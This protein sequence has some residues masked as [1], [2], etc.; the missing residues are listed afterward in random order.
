[1]ETFVTESLVSKNLPTVVMVSLV[2]TPEGCV[3]VPD[4]GDLVKMIVKSKRVTNVGRDECC[5]N[6]C[7]M[8][9]VALTKVVKRYYHLSIP[10]EIDFDHCCFRHHAIPKIENTISG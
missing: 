1:M 10:F 3:P 7:R 9:S 6:M 2:T 5:R 8:T 4:Q